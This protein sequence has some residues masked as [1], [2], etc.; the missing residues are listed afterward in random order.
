ML[1]NSV[2]ILERESSIV[3][4]YAGAELELEGVKDKVGLY[5]YLEKN[6]ELRQ[7]LGEHDMLRSTPVASQTIDALE[8][9]EKHKK[10]GL[11]ILQPVYEHRIWDL[12][13][14][15]DCP[16][17]LILGF[18]LE[19]YHYIE[20][21]HEHMAFAA[22][23]SSEFMMTH[24]AKHFIEE[25]THGDIYKYGM[26]EF[27]TSEQVENS[28]PLPTTRALV[29]SLSE[30]AMEDSFCYYA[31]NELLQL[32]EN[33]DDDDEA[34]V[35]EFYELMLKSHP[36]SAKIVKAYRLH[37]SLDQ[38]LGHEGAFK[39]MCK[40]IG[41]ISVAQANKA[42][43]NTAKTAELLEVFLDGICEYYENSVSALRV[44]SAVKCK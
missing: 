27:F 43:A 36:W 32:T 31:A 16:K 13:I 12:L 25:Y 38:N 26:S 34:E 37:T 44:P 1:K 6:Q 33:V 2:A 9:Y 28:V 42:I 22:A 15:K 24:L 40:S 8:F 30:F 4:S 29:N 20:G 41:T 3:L 39:K 14:H 18:T 11:N 19:K 5:E 10:Y 23:D 17:N 7:I 35:G 21:A